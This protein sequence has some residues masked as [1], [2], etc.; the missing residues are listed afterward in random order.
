MP[1]YAEVAGCYSYQ[2]KNNLTSPQ[3]DNFGA[4][5]T[6]SLI[7]ANSAASAGL[8]ENNFDC[9][10]IYSAP[11]SCHYNINDYENDNSSYPF[12]QINIKN[13]F[14]SLSNNRPKKMSIIENKMDVINNFNPPSS[15]D[16]DGQHSSTAQVFGTIKRNRLTKKT[17]A[18]Q[19]MSDNK[20]NFGGCDNG[21]TLEQ[22]LFVKSKQ[23]GTWTSVQNTSSLNSYHNSISDSF[24]KSNTLKYLSSFGK[25][26]NV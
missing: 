12:T 20:I 7:A 17:T 1:D 22:Q 25:A 26:D 6:T 11:T 5:A 9:K 21:R 14:T 19:G 15:S 24:N 18:A 13:N 8:I 4:Y 2:Q 10:N 23:N 3:S 16:V